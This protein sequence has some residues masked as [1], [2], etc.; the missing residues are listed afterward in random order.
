MAIFQGVSESWRCEHD[1]SA[2]QTQI[3][4]QFLLAFPGFKIKFQG[5]LRN[6]TFSRA[7]PGLKVHFCKFWGYSRFPGM[8]G[9]LLGLTCKIPTS[10]GSDRKRKINE[11]ISATKSGILIMK[12]NCTWNCKTPH[13]H[14]VQVG[15]IFHPVSLAPER[16]A[17]LNVIDNSQKRG[18]LIMA[19]MPMLLTWVL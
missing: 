6:Q 17:E 3:K 5:I 14:R 19:E 1:Y 13:I 7:F 18:C 12:T 8:M 15:G 9:T 2:L 11:G 16:T 10:I 4:I